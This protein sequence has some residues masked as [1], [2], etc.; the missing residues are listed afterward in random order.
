MVWRYSRGI[1]EV[2]LFNIF[3]KKYKEFNIY[4]K[5][6]IDKQKE[7]NMLNQWNVTTDLIMLQILSTVLYI[8]GA[9]LVFNFQLSIGAVFAFI[10]YSA[11][12][13]GPISAI[14]NIGYLL[15]G[16]IPLQKDIITL[17]LCMRKMIMGILLYLI[18]E[19]WC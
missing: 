18:L 10:T 8:V 9:N 5:K 7:M 4:Q 13:T 1:N 11:Y 12:V 2:K 14:L 3:N 16:I 15:S 19:S 17:W 6:V